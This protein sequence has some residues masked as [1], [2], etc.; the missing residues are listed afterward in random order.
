MKCDMLSLRPLLSQSSYHVCALRI[1]NHLAE[2]AASHQTQALGN[3]KITPGG[4]PNHIMD[5]TVI[6]DCAWSKQR[7]TAVYGVAVVMSW[8]SGKVPDCEV[9]SKHCS[10]CSH[11][12]GCDRSSDEYGQW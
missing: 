8:K 3:L 12:E 10:T 4:Q 2:I 6:C 9:L 5:L 11:W 1:C 7:F